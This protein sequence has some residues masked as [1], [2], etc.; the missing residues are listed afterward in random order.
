MT[1]DLPADRLIR[2]LQQKLL[3]IENIPQMKESR[4]VDSFHPEVQNKAFWCYSRAMTALGLLHQPRMVFLARYTEAWATF[5]RSAA[6]AF[7]S[8]TNRPIFQTPLPQIL[9]LHHFPE[10]PTLAQ[11]LRDAGVMVLVKRRAPWMG[12]EWTLSLDTTNVLHRL[13]AHLR[14]GGSVAA[15]L[16]HSFPDTRNEVYPFLGIPSHTPMG[17]LHLAAKAR[18][19]VG[20]IEGAAPANSLRHV[21]NDG[22]P[23]ALA[24]TILQHLDDMILRAPERWLLWP[25][26]N[27]RWVQQDIC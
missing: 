16:D 1:L 27:H 15:M 3:P 9:I 11:G 2:A 14:S 5:Y 22:H 18:F 20:V 13:L 19:S 23:S 21:Q 24:T 10:Y 12:M 8:S 17:L 4:A 6:Q 26:L 7:T 25:N